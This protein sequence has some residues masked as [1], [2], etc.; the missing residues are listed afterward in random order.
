[1]QNFATR[2]HLLDSK[3]TISCKQLWTKNFHREYIISYM[4]F[5]SKYSWDKASL[6]K[7]ETSKHSIYNTMLFR[8]RVGGRGRLLLPCIIRRTPGLLNS[9]SG[10]RSQKHPPGAGPEEAHAAP[11]SLMRGTPHPAPDAA[12]SVN[13]FAQE[14][15]HPRARASQN[16]KQS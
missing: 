8:W 6:G 16:A 12:G 5:Y 14:R 4:F 15:P 13:A 9:H 3:L 2:W 10:T 7:R 11:S 1:M